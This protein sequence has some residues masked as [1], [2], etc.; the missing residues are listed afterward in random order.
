MGTNQG[1][2]SSWNKLFHGKGPSPNSNRE[3]IWKSE[4]HLQLQLMTPAPI[5]WYISALGIM[6]AICVLSLEIM[7]SVNHF[8]EKF[9]CCHSWLF[10]TFTQL[11]L[12]QPQTH[13]SIFAECGTNFSWHQRPDENTTALTFLL[14]FIIQC[15]AGFS[16]NIFMTI[17]MIIHFE[18]LSRKNCL[19]FAIRIA[20]S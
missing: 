18:N 4:Y 8:E 16:S 20:W 9:L 5:N 12:T 13:L 19:V 11:D 6:R 15:D 2:R 3:S 10:R 17:I 1:F 7:L 14:K